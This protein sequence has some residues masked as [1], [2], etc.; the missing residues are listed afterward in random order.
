MRGPCLTR[1]NGCRRPGEAPARGAFAHEPLRR[2]AIPGGL[3]ILARVLQRARA[4]VAEY[5]YAA[6]PNVRSGERSMSVAPNLP[7]QSAQG[8]I[9]R[10]LLT[11]AIATVI[12]SAGL[13]PV[14]AT[15]ARMRNAEDMMI[16]DCL[17]PGQVR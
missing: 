13:L 9:R 4:A 3:D 16:V 5:G 1:G 2:R 15:A 8:A 7:A 11:V 6:H 12:G 10:S 14:D 17:L